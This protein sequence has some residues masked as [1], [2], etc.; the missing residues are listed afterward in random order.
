[1]LS[2]RVCLDSAF[3]TRARSRAVSAKCCSKAVT[4]AS[5]GDD[6]LRTRSLPWRRFSISRRRWRKRLD[7]RLAPLA[8]GEEVVF[9]VGVALHHPDVA[10]HLVEH[11]RRAA[12]DALG[13]QLV[14]QR[15]VF[16]RRAAE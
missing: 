16:P 15:P 11:P 5:A 3:L 8:A 2:R 9:Q 4:A 7:Q 12:G 10:E 14:E 6:Q 13:A 1:M